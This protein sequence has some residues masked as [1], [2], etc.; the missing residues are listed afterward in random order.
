MEELYSL[1]ESQRE[2]LKIVPKGTYAYLYM[3]N[4]SFLG[5]K[6]FTTEYSVISLSGVDH[7]SVD[8]HDLATENSACIKIDQR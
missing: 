5:Y 8:V 6:R 4:G 3:S 1:Y 2:Q 7:K